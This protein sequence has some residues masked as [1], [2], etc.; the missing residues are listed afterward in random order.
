MLETIR[1]GYF[2]RKEKKEGRKYQDIIRMKNDIIL[3]KG[4]YHMEKSYT[5]NH[6]ITSFDISRNF[7]YREIKKGKIKTVEVEQAGRKIKALEKSELERILG[8]EISESQENIKETQEGEKKIFSESPSS[9]ITEETI[10]KAIEKAFLS[11]ENQIMKPI[12]EQALYLAGKF[13]TENKFLREKLEVFR[14]ENEALRENM[15]SLPGPGELH[16]AREEEK[17]YLATIEEL[18]KRLEEE[19]KKPFWKKLW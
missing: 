8:R 13:E 16:Q 4:K 10:E 6:I 15:K 7:L 19:E 18:K 14:E 2:L 11:R 1:E 9:Q 3:R 5:I 12:E 17:N